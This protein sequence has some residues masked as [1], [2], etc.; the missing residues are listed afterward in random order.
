[1]SGTAS[2]YDMSKLTAGQVLAF[3]ATAL[4][5]GAVAPILSFVSAIPFLLITIAYGIMMF[6][7]SY[8]EEEQ[9]FW[10]WSATGWLALLS[11]KGYE[12]FHQPLLYTESVLE[13]LDFLDSLLCLVSVG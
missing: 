5:F 1:M 6:A 13:S 4:A 10:Y 7:S 3:V 11:F 8:V 9:H 12:Y 2:N